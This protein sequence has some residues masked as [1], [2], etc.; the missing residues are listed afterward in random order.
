MWLV[1]GIITSIIQLVTSNIALDYV[2]G[3]LDRDIG[4]PQVELWDYAFS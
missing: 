2:V 1:L 4:M 3:I